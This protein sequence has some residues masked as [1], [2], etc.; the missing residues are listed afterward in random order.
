MVKVLVIRTAGTN[1]DKETVEAWEYVGA[2][3]S[4]LH[5]NELVRRPKLFSQFQILTIP[6]GFSYGDDLGAGK[7]LA[8]DLIYQLAEPLFNFVKAGK[9]ILGICNGFQVLLKAGLIPQVTL[10]NN[11]SARFECRWVRLLNVSKKCL[12]TKGI[13]SL[14]IPVAHGEG[15]F[16]A[17]N[18]VVLKDLRKNDQVVFQYVDARGKFGSY[19]VNPNGSEDN[20]AGIGDKNGLVLGLMP[21]PERCL[22]FY[23]LPW[24]IRKPKERVK[25]NLGWK[26]FENG[27]KYVKSC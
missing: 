11:D 22:N 23:Q 20:I 24:W 7:L 26:I 19:P 5:V 9:P 25:K 15:K 1:C 17:A 27:F 18:N 14:W 13:E 6:G 2:K 10:F 12:W 3:V 21:H 4:L 16:I 8:N